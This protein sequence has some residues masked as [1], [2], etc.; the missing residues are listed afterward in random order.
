MDQLLQLTAIHLV[1]LVAE[2]ALQ[3]VDPLWHSRSAGR[4]LLGGLKVA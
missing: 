1:D 3:Q 2:V 4:S